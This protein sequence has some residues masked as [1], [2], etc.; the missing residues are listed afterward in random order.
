MAPLH[1][2]GLTAQATHNTLIKQESDIPI[3]YLLELY[4]VLSNYFDDEYTKCTKTKA[5][6]KQDFVSHT[7]RV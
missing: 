5:L 4:L 7:E 1:E 3:M 2:L 6:S